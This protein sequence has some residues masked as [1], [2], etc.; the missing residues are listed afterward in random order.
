MTYIW[1]KSLRLKANSDLQEADKVQLTSNLTA[2][3]AAR[4]R[5]TNRP[6]FTIRTFDPLQSHFAWFYLRDLSLCYKCVSS[7]MSK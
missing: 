7:E 4:A 1:T 3:D 2:K 6:M 5:P